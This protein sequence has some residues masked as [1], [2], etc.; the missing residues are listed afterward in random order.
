M[1]EKFAT[2]TEYDDWLAQHY[3]EFDIISVVEEEDKS[4][5]IEYVTKEEFKKMNL[6]QGILKKAK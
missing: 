3:K 5:S 2:W 6:S 1:K 4:I